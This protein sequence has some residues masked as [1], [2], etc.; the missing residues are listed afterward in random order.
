VIPFLDLFLHRVKCLCVV[1]CIPL[2]SAPPLTRETQPEHA[3]AWMRL[4][5]RIHSAPRRQLESEPRSAQRRHSA[6]F[7]LAGRCVWARNENK[8]ALAGEADGW[9]AP[10]TT[11]QLEVTR[12]TGGASGGR[13]GFGSAGRA[14][15]AAGFLGQTATAGTPKKRKRPSHRV[16][17]LSAKEKYFGRGGK[18]G[19]PNRDSTGCGKAGTQGRVAVRPRRRDRRPHKSASP[20][21]KPSPLPEPRSSGSYPS[22]V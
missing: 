3:R 6:T 14:A 16:H 19:R 13:V 22:P 9:E 5:P 11:L 20:G 8:G 7:S 1:L 12:K 2:T 4:S 15:R 17:R 10:S 18:H 21:S